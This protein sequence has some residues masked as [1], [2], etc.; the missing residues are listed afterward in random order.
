MGERAQA[1]VCIDFGTSMSKAAVSIRGQ[2]PQPIAIGA[3]SRDPVK[4]YPVD[5]SLLFASDGGIYLGYHAIVESLSHRKRPQRRLDSL[6]RRL[7]TGDV[8]DLESVPLHSAFNA[9]GVTFN[10]AEV[11]VLFLAYLVALIERSLATDFDIEPNEVHYRFTRPVL[12]LDRS[13]WV[14][15]EMHRAMLRAIAFAHLLRGDVDGRLNAADAR[16]Y[17]DRCKKSAAPPEIVCGTG[18]LEPV[19]AGI[20]HLAQ[21]PNQRSLAAIVDIGAGTTDMAMFMA[22]Q[23][24]GKNLVDRVRTL[25]SPISIRKAGDYIDQ[26]LERLLVADLAKSLSDTDHIEIELNIRRWKEDLFKFGE[27]VATLSG[28]RKLRRVLPHV[29]TA[30]EGFVEFES[31]LSAALTKLVESQRRTIELIAGSH[32]FP[33]RDIYLIPA[34]GGASL[35]V[36]PAL[37]KIRMSTPH[38]PVGFVLKQPVPEGHRPYD[39]TFPQL[40]VALGGALT[41]LPRVNA[42][43]LTQTPLRGLSLPIAP[44]S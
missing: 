37:S 9:T 13:G 5:S 2:D 29:L 44:P 23:P 16:K 28:G 11:L 31:E 8:C 3:E 4:D 7:T 1:V 6:K 32:Q 35:P 18:F 25:G 36:F 21:Y 26:L 15:R 24:D 34:G 10:I 39:E 17:L 19:A 22:I 41:D 20:L 27:T 12:D 30:S 43:P 38:G 33:S 42:A 14:D 40:A